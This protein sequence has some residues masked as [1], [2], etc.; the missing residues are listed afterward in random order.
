M[1]K[2]SYN[3]RILLLLFFFLLSIPSNCDPTPSTITRLTDNVVESFIISSSDDAGGLL[4][5]RINYLYEVQ[6]S[7]KKIA[8]YGK[9]YREESSAPYLV[10]NFEHYHL[11]DSELNLP[12]IR[13]IGLSDSDK[14][15][16]SIEHQGK[17]YFSTKKHTWP[18]EENYYA[19]P[20]LNFNRF[21]ITI[22]QRSKS[23]SQMIKG[24]ITVLN[25]NMA[26]T[27]TPIQS[28]KNMVLPVIIPRGQTSIDIEYHTTSRIA[29]GVLLAKM[30]SGWILGINITS[31]SKLID[32]IKVGSETDS[33]FQIVHLPAHSKVIVS[34]QLNETYK[35][36]DTVVKLAL[37]ETNGMGAL[38]NMM[39]KLEIDAN[40]SN[41]DITW[42]NLG[43]SVD[44]NKF[45]TFSVFYFDKNLE[46]LKFKKN[47]GFSFQIFG[48]SYPSPKHASIKDSNKVLL[49]STPERNTTGF[50]FPHLD[51][52]EKNNQQLLDLK[53][54]FSFKL[55]TGN[56]LLYSS[57]VYFYIKETLS[58]K[59]SPRMAKIDSDFFFVTKESTPV[60]LNGKKDSTISNSLWRKI[61]SWL[62]RFCI[63]VAGLGIIGA[64]FAY[65]CRQKRLKEE[66][67]R[68]MSGVNPEKNKIETEIGY[69]R[70]GAEGIP[71]FGRSD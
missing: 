68:A 5:N 64:L 10:I 61:V 38:F 20:L 70:V 41:G 71:T 37:L 14:E 34:L 65:R 52:D 57:T 43:S 62:I 11:T 47:C 39:N 2:R 31:D 7:T 32:S 15:E 51:L 53:D 46:N 45:D 59:V 6:K 30:C 16:D 48:G 24:Y 23:K 22:S 21:N 13:I 49:E 66:E 44:R 55:G 9:Q 67:F 12:S 54:L 40:Y 50:E 63:Q 17:F 18:F 36:V 26:E 19:I 60:L 25:K 3:K 27:K 56:N 4:K 35:E 8:D 33:V 29:N 1:E 42:K 58:P 69:S 28:R